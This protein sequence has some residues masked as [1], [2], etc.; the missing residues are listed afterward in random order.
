[1][2]MVGVAGSELIPNGPRGGFSPSRGIG[3]GTLSM[4][5][6]DMVVEEG[7]WTGAAVW[8]ARGD[9]AERECDGEKG[10]TGWVG[11]D[12]ERMGDDGISVETGG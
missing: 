8:G 6:T 3:R 2:V 7:D 5:V 12:D 9:C 4:S 11:V 1:M 10:G